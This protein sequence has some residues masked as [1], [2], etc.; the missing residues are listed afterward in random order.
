[1]SEITMTIESGKT[2]ALHTAGKYCD[3]NIVATAEVGGNLTEEQKA[4][5]TAKNWQ[6]VY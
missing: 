2:R 6:L 1:M 5:I 3:R 4:A